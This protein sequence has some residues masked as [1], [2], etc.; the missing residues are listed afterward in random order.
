MQVA[1]D[2]PPVT[3][4]KIAVPEA[5]MVKGS[6]A[7]IRRK[8]VCFIQNGTSKIN[9]SGAGLREISLQ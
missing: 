7:E 5:R 3:A 1:Y 9:F 4:S 6:S 8:K 2:A